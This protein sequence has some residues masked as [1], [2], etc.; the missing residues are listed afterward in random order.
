MEAAILDVT[1]HHFRSETGPFVRLSVCERILKTRRPNFTNSTVHV[2]CGCGSGFLWRRCDM[3]CISGFADDIT[4][5]HSQ[6]K[7]TQCK[8]TRQDAWIRHGADDHRSPATL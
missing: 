6:F 5:A 8:V 2:A 1:S 4:F 7:A 3:L